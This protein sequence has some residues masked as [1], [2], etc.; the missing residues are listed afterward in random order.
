MSNGIFYSRTH[1]HTNTSLKLKNGHM[2]MYI[3]EV[4]SSA[5]SLSV[6]MSGPNWD[7]NPGPSDY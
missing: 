6:E 2:C 4:T 1:I 7:L 3:T 5:E